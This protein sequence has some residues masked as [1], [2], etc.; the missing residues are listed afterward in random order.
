MLV[1]HKPTE[2]APIPLAIHHT[3]FCFTFAF[4]PDP[5]IPPVIDPTQ[6][7]Q[8]LSA[9]LLSIALNAQRELC[10]L[11]KLGGVPLATDEVM[12]IVQVAVQKAKELNNIVND[13]LTE[14]W[15]TRKVEVR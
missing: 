7:E 10:V 3:P 1:Q 12:Q 9:G 5:A 4:Y 2:R 6:L 15:G 13:R 11:Q 14:D 8:R